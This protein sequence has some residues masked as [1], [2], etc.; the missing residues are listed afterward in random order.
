MN[1]PKIAM[2]VTGE[3]AGYGAAF[4]A[5]IARKLLD[6]FFLKQWP[7]DVARDTTWTRKPG[8]T[9][10]SAAPADSTPQRKGPF[11]KP[12]AER[13]V[14]TLPRPATPVAAQPAAPQR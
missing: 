7:A 14:A 5:P 10:R 2:V 12:Y 4:A 9:P 11:A 3:G 1:D 8:A 6:L 13:P